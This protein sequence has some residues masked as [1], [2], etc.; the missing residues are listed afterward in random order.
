MI[1]NLKPTSCL[2]KYVISKQW[3]NITQRLMSHPNDTH[4]I[5]QTNHITT[6]HVAVQHRDMP[7]D[8]LRRIMQSYMQ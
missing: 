7:V 8:T 2:I 5:E 4:F 3:D 1:L 6:L